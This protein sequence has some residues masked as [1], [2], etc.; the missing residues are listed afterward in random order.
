M[1]LSDAEVLQIAAMLLEPQ[2]V[3]RAEGWYEPLCWNDEG[4]YTYFYID[5]LRAMSPFSL[6]MFNE[7]IIAYDSVQLTVSNVV[8]VSPGVYKIYCDIANKPQGITVLNKK[9][10][11][12]S[13]ASGEQLSAFSIHF[14]VAGIAAYVR[15][16]Y[17]YETLEDIP[18]ISSA[19]DA[20]GEFVFWPN[21][22]C[23][24]TVE[25]ANIPKISNATESVSV[26]LT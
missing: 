24:T 14:F 7:S 9:T 1:S 4:V 15:L 2:N 8:Y 5:F 23:T 20:V 12:L 26:F 22:E 18:T 11:L 13:F 6:G 16:K 3:V 17:V 25:T 21:E 19:E 10:S